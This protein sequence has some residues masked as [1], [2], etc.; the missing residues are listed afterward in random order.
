MTQELSSPCSE[1]IRY[2]RAVY[3]SSDGIDGGGGVGLGLGGGGG[4]GDGGMSGGA[5]GGTMGGDGGAGGRK[6]TRAL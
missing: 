6:Y 2:C 3:S 4:T 1:Q 5:A